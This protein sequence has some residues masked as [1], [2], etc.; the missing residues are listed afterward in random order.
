[1]ID[2]FAAA[3]S[4]SILA[5]RSLPSAASTAFVAIS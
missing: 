3:G 5:A 4:I 1:L 2:A